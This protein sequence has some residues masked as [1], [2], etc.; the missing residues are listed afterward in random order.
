MVDGI[1]AGD[2]EGTGP[3]AAE[4]CHAVGRAPPWRTM[5]G[6]GLKA[7]LRAL[8]LQRAQHVGRPAV[9]F[10]CEAQPGGEAGTRWGKL[11]RKGAGEKGRNL[12]RRGVTLSYGDTK[13]WNWSCPMSGPSQ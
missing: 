1:A 2:R 8:T 12:A 3:W 5:A 11:T 13:L 10:L 6:E 7:G 4:V 9:G